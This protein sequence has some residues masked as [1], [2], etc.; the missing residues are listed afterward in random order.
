L[1]RANARPAALAHL[2]VGDAERLQGTQRVARD[3]P[4]HAEARREVLL[5][6]E[7]IAG[8]ELSWP[9]S[10]SRTCPTICAES[11]GRVAADEDR[12]GVPRGGRL[13]R[14]MDGHGRSGDSIV[15]IVSY[16]VERQ[17][18]GKATRRFITDTCSA[19]S[20]Q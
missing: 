8:L 5:G 2:D 18:L 1:P 19:C 6:A 15:K 4:A 7:E 14:R 20:A 11:D 10:A 12:R 17:L 13:D 3:D 16:K 9:S